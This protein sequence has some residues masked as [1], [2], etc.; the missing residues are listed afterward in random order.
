[1]IKFLLRRGAGA[2]LSLL[3]LTASVF[4]LL[5]LAPGD[6]AAVAAGVGA[7]PAQ[8]A[9][10]R[11]K[12]G[13]N[14][15]LVVQFGSFLVRTLQGDLGVSSST[16]ASVGAQLA[17]VVPATLGLVAL[18]TLMIVLVGL[19]LATVSV[20]RTRRGLDTAVSSTIVFIAA[21]P[22]FWLA[23][24]LQQ[25]LGAQLRVLPIS[26]ELDRQYSVP[27]ASGFAPL[28]AVLIGNWAAAGN[29]FV[30][31]FLP[32]AV[33]AVSFGAQ[34]F[35]AQRAEI[36]QILQ[37]DHVV[38]ARMK[39]VTPMR[40]A[41]KHVLPNAAGPALTV[42][43]ITFG[44]MVG[45]AVLV[46]SVF[47]LAGVGS[48]LNNAVAQKDVPSVLGAVLVIGAIVVTANLLVDIA[49]LVRDPRLRRAETR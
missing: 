35:R 25:V 39:G 48:Y 24:V 13:L 27:S 47:G 49:Q 14:Q 36:L 2:L 23:L 17:G 21:I 34:F 6:E 30:H 4:L 26:G 10:E 22:T 32:A 18:A 7:T 20:F 41:L 8:V 31:L 43:G 19:P 15:P 12:L 16:H 44:N 33:L 29:A 40:L 9:A 28:D 11:E 5:K 45:G 38:F 3:L 42:L 37:Q 1:M 46:E